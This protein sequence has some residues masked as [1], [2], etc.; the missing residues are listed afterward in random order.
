MWETGG[1][2][3][4]LPAKELL[5]HRLPGSFF[6]RE[7]LLAAKI[8]DELRRAISLI[9]QAAFERGVTT[10]YVARPEIFTH[11]ESLSWLRDKLGTIRDHLS[12]SD[13]STV[14]VIPGMR[15]H[16]FFH[17][18]GRRHAASDLTQL[19]RRAP[20]LLF[21]IGAQ[22]NSALRFRDETKSHIP[23]PMALEGNGDATPTEAEFYRFYLNPYS[24]EDSVARTVHRGA[25]EIAE[26]STES[27]LYAPLTEV[28][29]DDPAFTRVLASAI[30]RALLDPSRAVVMRLP[31]GGEPDFSVTDRLKITL[32]ALNGADALIPGAPASRVFFATEDV[33]I[34]QLQTISE[35]MDFFAHDSYDFWRHSRS[36]YGAFGS[37][38]V[39]ARRGRHGS[40]ALS[41]L[42]AQLLGRAPELIW[43]QRSDMRSRT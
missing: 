9:E 43:P 27:L 2:A 37:L 18:L 36:F 23:E 11:A 40:G 33:D 15:N 17:A 35:N 20:E 21:S 22:I 4:S 19:E 25:V 42:L 28:S 7:H 5:G 32:A 13:A 39:A 6:G 24:I 3:V 30:A 38:R 1:L 26:A 41:S 31:F 8:S 10:I 12:I 34:A 29:L 16:V 14:R